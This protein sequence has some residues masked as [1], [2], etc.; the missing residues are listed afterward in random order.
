[1]LDT[2]TTLTQLIRFV[3]CFVDMIVE[4]EELSKLVESIPLILFDETKWKVLLDFFMVLCD[5]SAGVDWIRKNRIYRYFGDTLPVFL[6]FGFIEQQAFSV[7][8]FGL[9]EQSR[10]SF[11]QSSVI[12]HF[13]LCS[14]FYFTL[15]LLLLVLAGCFDK[16]S[17]VNARYAFAPEQRVSCNIIG[18]P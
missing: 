18:T 13:F 6:R 17:S 14:G 12:F 16:N 10:Q 11:P 8:F 2:L 7:I 9:R 5:T 1:M 3:P 15:Y 4:T